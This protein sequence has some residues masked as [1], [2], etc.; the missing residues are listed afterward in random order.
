MLWA[1]AWSLL[2]SDLKHCT[3]RAIC[4][5]LGIKGGWAKE[6]F[7][8]MCTNRAIQEEDNKTRMPVRCRAPGPL[9]S[10]VLGYLCSPSLTSSHGS[11]C[12]SYH[13][14]VVRYLLYP[15]TKLN[16]FNGEV[17]ILKFKNRLWWIEKLLFLKDKLG[18][19]SILCDS[20]SGTAMTL[21]SFPHHGPISSWAGRALS[22][23]VQGF[24]W[25][26][27]RFYCRHL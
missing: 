4:H 20:V 21:V 8:Q 11:A 23:S 19:R 18:L 26:V 16:I 13:S 1:P 9:L 24:W 14:L 6:S 7:L 10:G 3:A 27:C 2:T 17:R 5:Y 12:T 15:L 25:A 22:S